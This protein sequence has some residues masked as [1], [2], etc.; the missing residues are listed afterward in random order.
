MS[1]GALAAE[2]ADER[3]ERLAHVAAAGGIDDGVGGRVEHGQRDGVVGGAQEHGAAP[4]IASHVHGEEGKER[5]P[6]GDE[7]AHDEGQRAQEAQR[8]AWAAAA[9][10]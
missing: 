10:R 6:A 7:D 1:V 4:A 3:S 5:R 8:A 9:G 2:A